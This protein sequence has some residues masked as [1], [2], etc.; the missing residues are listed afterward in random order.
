M[1]DCDRGWPLVL[2]SSV[3]HLRGMTC[4][5]VC[6]SPW[7]RRRCSA[8]SM[9]SPISRPRSRRSIPPIKPMSCPSIW[10]R[11]SSSDWLPNGTPI[12]SSLLPTGC[13]CSSTRRTHL[14]EDPTRQLHAVRRPPAP[15]H[16]S[17]YGSRPKT[18]LGE[19][20]LLTNAHG[21]PSLAAELKAEID[22]ADS[23]DL[24]CAFV[25][26][27]GLRLLERPLQPSTRGRRSA[28]RR[29]D[30]LHR[31][32]RAGGPRP[33]GPRVRCRGQGAVRRGAHAAARQGLAVS[34]QHWLRHGVR[35]LLQPLHERAPGRRRVE[36]PLS[37]QAHRP[38]C[39][40]S[41]PPSTPTGTA[42]SSSPTTPTRDRDRLDDA[43]IA[44]RGGTVWRSRHHLH[45]GAGGAAVPLPTGD[46]GRDRGR[47]RRSRPPPQPGRRGDRHRQD[48]HRRAGLPPALRTVATG[49]ACSS[50]RTGGRSSSS[51]CAPTARS[52][53]TATS[54]SCTSAAPDRSAGSTSSR[55]SSR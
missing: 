41:R 47:A 35:R 39:R 33:S 21:E 13:C 20:A 29:H 2:A 55:A 8:S 45:L 25:M 31:W 6:T 28:P 18:P 44:A 9:G 4:T 48:S 7:S 23:I 49:L 32:D 52:W 46:P 34:T 10:R 50:S 42:P 53:A 51:P 30:H 5:K 27:R 43:L 11:Q 38:C 36:R 14:V 40:S 37:Q 16:V 19:A 22:S 24:L 54:A 15:G 17:R 1:S 12:A 26:W 3:L